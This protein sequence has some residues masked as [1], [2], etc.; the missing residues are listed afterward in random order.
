[1]FADDPLL[2]LF[3]IMIPSLL[4]DFLRLRLAIM[5]ALLK[6]SEGYMFVL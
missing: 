6:S 5:L 1:M 2:K 3:I 4:P